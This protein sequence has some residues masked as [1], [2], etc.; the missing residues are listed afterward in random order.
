MNTGSPVTIPGDIAPLFSAA[1]VNDGGLRLS[2]KSTRYGKLA[3]C[4]A[5]TIRQHL[6]T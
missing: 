6:F 4:F 3:S 5:D 1:T 2:M